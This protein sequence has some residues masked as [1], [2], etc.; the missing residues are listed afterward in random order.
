MSA[1]S[2]RRQNFQGV[3]SWAIYYGDVFLAYSMKRL[4]AE[5]AKIE[6][7]RNLAKQNRVQANEAPMTPQRRVYYNAAMKRSAETG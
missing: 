7:E 6:I 5:K 4:A 1:L 2:I 3:P